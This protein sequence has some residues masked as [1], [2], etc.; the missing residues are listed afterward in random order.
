MTYV[1]Y[2]LR[3]PGDVE[4]RYVGMTRKS[5]DERLAAF[6]REAA[7]AM[8]FRGTAWER[9]IEPDSFIQWI[10]D[11]DVETFV[12]ARASTKGEA[13]ET[14][15]AVAAIMLRLNH[16]LFNTWLVPAERRIGWNAKVSA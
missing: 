15:R 10:I 9:K 2:G 16:R 11:H 12:I 6:T 14:E 5:P 1:I 8:R 7:R 13:H 4:C 3:L